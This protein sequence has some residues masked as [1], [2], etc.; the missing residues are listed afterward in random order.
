MENMKILFSLTGSGS[1]A[2]YHHFGGFVEF[3]I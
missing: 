3:R 1:Y 2:E